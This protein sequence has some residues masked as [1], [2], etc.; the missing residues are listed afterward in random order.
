[1][2]HR[3][4]VHGHRGARAILPENTLPAF[5][6]AIRAGV[7]GIELD[8]AV[9][10]DN[11]A[12]VSHDPAL[13]DGTV[14]RE[15]AAAAL[16]PHIPTLAAVLALAAPTAVDLSIELKS[17]PESP[18]FTPPPDEFAALVLQEIEGRHLGPRCIVQSFD[19]RILHAAKAQAPEIRRAAI[20]ANDPRPFAAIAAAGGVPIVSALYKD[21]TPAKVAAAHRAGITIMAWTVNRPVEWDAMISAGVDVLITDDPAALIAHLSRWQAT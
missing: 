18:Q 2:P 17:D 9:T 19:F 8:V 11:V 4:Q 14:I 15:S 1:V 20:V 3:I 16:P 10:R 5:E 7:D 12:V 21:I 13:P 6:Y